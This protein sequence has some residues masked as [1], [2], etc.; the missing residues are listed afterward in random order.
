MKH[1]L[2][3]RFSKRGGVN[4]WTSQQFDHSFGYCQATAG[5]DAHLLLCLVLRTADERTR[6]LR[7]F[8]KMAFPDCTRVMPIYHLVV[9]AKAAAAT[10]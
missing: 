3:T 9:K 2:S 6:S 8:Q 5:V 7:A 4:I 1:G 10:G